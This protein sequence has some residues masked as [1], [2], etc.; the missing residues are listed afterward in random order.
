MVRTV[1]VIPHTHWDREWYFTTSRSMVYLLKDFGDVL[2]NLESNPGYDRFVLDGQSSLIEDYLALRPQDELRVRQLVADGKLILGPWYTQTDQFVISGESIVRNLQYGMD[3]AD[4]LGA[5]MNV[6]YVPDSFG[7]ESSMPQI[8]Q[9]MGIR[10]TL[11]WRGVSRQDSERT[12]FIWRG[13]DGSTV[14]AYQ[15]PYG[16][17]I[18]G[19][20]DETKLAELM[21]EE[22]FASIVER[23]TT[24]HI[25]FP[26]GFD[27]A[28]ARRDLP[29]LVSELNRLNESFRF[30]VSSIEEYIEAVRSEDPALETIEGELTNGRDMRIHK[31]IYSSRSDLKKLN[32]ELQHYLVNILEPVLSMGDH[33]GIEYPRGAMDRLWKLMFENAAHDSIGSCVSDTTNEDIRMRYK[34]VRDTSSSLV[35]ITLRQ[36]ATRIAGRADQ[37]ITCTLFNTMPSARSEVAHVML[38][39]PSAQ[40]KLID[41]KGG[42]LPMVIES[43]EE[44]SEYILA[45]TIQL[46]PGEPIY[47]PEKVYRIQADIAVQDLPAMGYEQLYLCETADSAQTL[48]ETDDRVLENDFLR[49]SVE[50]D[51]S[52]TILD[53][54]S[55]RIYANQAVLEEN[56]DGGDSFNYSPAKEDMVISST[57]QPCE[58]QVRR[59]DLVDIAEIRFDFAVP[60]SLEDRARAVTQAKMPVTLTARLEKGSRLI[61]FRITADNREPMDHRLCVCFDTGIASSV[62]IADLQ[63]GT[64]RR[65]VFR[66]KEMQRWELEPQSWNEKPIAIE[67]CQ[68]FV[69]LSDELQTVAVMPQGVR[70]YEIIGDEHSTIRLTLFRTYGMMGKDD[71]LFRPGRAS[72]EK[73][74]ATPA[75][76]LNEVLVFD[77]AHL[78]VD[79]PFDSAQVAQTAKRYNTPIQPYEYA[80]FLNGRLI[81]EL[82]RV[83][84]MLP[85]S[86][87][88]LSCTGALVLS[89]LKKAH[90]RSGYIARFYNA[91]AQ[92]SLSDSVRFTRTPARVELVDLKEENPERLEVCDNEVVLADIGH[93]KVVTLYF[94]Y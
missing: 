7:Q 70:E 41:A 53:K 89:T 54:Q 29:D 61:K 8:Y 15:I 62:S 60:R 86:D 25:A 33:L 51:G 5:H 14:C 65:P 68:S 13:E 48:R 21:R 80:D 26:N 6:G 19:V 34:Q 2:A 55:G 42:E 35:E 88:L 82:D 93:A 40:V 49:I 59:S 44:M 18:G 72:G 16:Y 78:I 22:P 83:N 67:T 24:S 27:Q 71:L 45:Q 12:E 79:A 37:P 57:D 63:F 76:E 64:I 4:R 92:G 11:F 10:D 73:V 3:I 38:Y 20:I 30:E 91:N 9:G 94:E 43:A 75:A 81:F 28:P 77:F 17:Y 52:L 50:D 87:E 90:H 74:V 66:K 31:S 36:I 84:R 1:H 69:A 32:T 56:G 58:I 46:D 39:A 85:E 47:R 23:S